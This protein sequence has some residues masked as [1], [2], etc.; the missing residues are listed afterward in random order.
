MFLFTDL[1]GTAKDFSKF[2]QEPSQPLS[3]IIPFGEEK[4]GNGDSI[5]S[6]KSCLFAFDEK[7]GILKLIS[8]ILKYLRK[9]CDAMTLV[10]YDMLQHGLWPLLPIL[11]NFGDK[12]LISE[13]LSMVDELISRDCLTVSPQGQYQL[14][15]L[16]FALIKN[17][18]YVQDSCALT[19]VLILELLAEKNCGSTDL[20]KILKQEGSSLWQA[21][22]ST[23]P[24]H[25]LVHLDS[26][27]T[28]AADEAKCAKSLISKVLSTNLKCFQ[29]ALVCLVVEETRQSQAWQKEQEK[30]FKIDRGEEKV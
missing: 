4:E 10:S 13:A 24:D 5:F 30:L 1:A 2:Q 19:A 14:V 9:E 8:D 3:K 26:C 18:K 11:L 20:K 17:P 6:T 21:D 12:F 28:L 23:F 7:K 25:I 16:L 29:V 27:L 22:F 15:K